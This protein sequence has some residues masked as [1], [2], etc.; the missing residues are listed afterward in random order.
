MYSID[1]N[2]YYIDYTSTPLEFSLTCGVFSSC[3]KCSIYDHFFCYSCYSDN[4]LSAYNLLTM[5][6]LC[7]NNCTNISVY[8]YPAQDKCVKCS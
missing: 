6:N 8:Y 1:S 3:Q 4:T 5:N 2:G 7:T